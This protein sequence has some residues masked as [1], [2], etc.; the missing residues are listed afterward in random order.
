M[1]N[2]F[3]RPWRTC[4]NAWSHVPDRRP[5]GA[6]C[7]CAHDSTTSEAR[8]GEFESA[9]RSSS[10]SPGG[11][12]LTSSP[13]THGPRGAVLDPMAVSANA[14]N[15]ARSPTPGLSVP[16][17]YGCLHPQ[18][19][20]AR[21]WARG[22]YA[23]KRAGVRSRCPPAGMPLAV[24]SDHRRPRLTPAGAPIPASVLR[25]GLLRQ[26]SCS[27][28]RVTSDA[29]ARRALRIDAGRRRCPGSRSDGDTKGS[30]TG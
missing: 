14:R 23:P 21:T 11:T 22:M 18:I 27:P 1:F 8:F 9:A 24:A 7:W 20:A 29:T 12:V 6:T 30:T 25:T 3:R 19:R 13:A 5:F 15:A 16:N 26:G 2:R 17:R 28:V 10:P 4:S